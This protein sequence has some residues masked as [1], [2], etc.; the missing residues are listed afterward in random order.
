MVPVPASAPLS[1]GG[2]SRDREPGSNRAS[3]RTCGSRGRVPGATS[4]PAAVAEAAAAEVAAGGAAGG[5][6]RGWLGG[7]RFGGH[8]G[9]FPAVQHGHVGLLASG[10][11]AH[12][13]TV[14]QAAVKATATLW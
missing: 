11:R 3:R 14:P 6:G 5:R 12:I 10:G 2:K 7:G 4:A 8:I 13:D 9:A 1:S